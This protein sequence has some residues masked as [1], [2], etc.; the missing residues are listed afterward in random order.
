MKS[1]TSFF[2]VPKGDNDVQVV[3]NGTRSGLNDSL[4]AHWFRLP[5]I[6][7]HL[8]AVEAGTFMADL[9]VGEQ[10]LNFIIDSAVQPFAGVDLTSYFPEELDSTISS[11]PSKQACQKQTLF[12]RWTR[13]AMGFKSSPYQVRQGMLHAEEQLRGDPLDISN[14]F[15]FDD[16]VLNLPGSP[17]Y[18]PNKP[19]VY[20]F[21]SK[22]GRITQDLFVYVDDGRTTGFTAES[23][24]TCVR[25][26]AIFL[27]FLGIQDA[28]RKRRGPSLEP[29]A[30]AGSIIHTAEGSFRVMISCERRLKAKAMITWIHD[31]LEAGE[32]LDFKTLESYRGYL[33]Y[34][35]QTYPMLAPYLKGIH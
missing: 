24:W 11:N 16:L 17:D 3:Y 5:T 13:C 30:W 22:A 6:E 33:V 32:H 27:D 31:C 1:L 23:T 4:W 9:D 26:V 2:T 15:F 28:P 10:F 29:G 12:V 7:Q 8:R 18:N 25:K 34:I 35:S 14:P 20:K 19:W 21:N